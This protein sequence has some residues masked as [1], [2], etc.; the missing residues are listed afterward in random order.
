MSSSMTIAL[1]WAAALSSGLMGGV[2][3]AFSSFIM[4]AF[5]TL[6]TSQAVAAMNAINTTILRSLFMPVF[7]GSSII[8]LSLVVIGLSHWGEAG[9]ELTLLAGVIYLT[10]MFIC[11]VIFNVPLNNML[12]NTAADGDTAQQA[13]GHY[14]SAWVMWNHI[15]TISSVTTCALCILILSA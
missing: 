1:L 3:L 12:E 9:S 5:D 6:G 13:W 11:T 2:Y 7:F 4:R 8:S 14:L 10:G 15:R